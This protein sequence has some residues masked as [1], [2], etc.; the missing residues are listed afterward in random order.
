MARPDAVPSMQQLGVRLPIY[1]SLPSISEIN[2]NNFFNIG[3]NLEAS[4][5]RPGLEISDRM[6]WSKGKHNMQFGGEWQHYT[7]EI[8]NQFRRVANRDQLIYPE[9]RCD[10]TDLPVSTLR[11]GTQFPHLAEHR[12]APAMRTDRGCAEHIQRRRHRRRIRRT[13]RWRPTGSR[14]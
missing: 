6:T 4:F 11:F 9:R 10:L 2:A 12:D 5:Y 8:R 13:T 1:P 14:W 3:D 7:V